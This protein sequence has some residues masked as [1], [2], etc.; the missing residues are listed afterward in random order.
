MSAICRGPEA[1]ADQNLSNLDLQLNLNCA[2]CYIN[3]GQPE[4][5]IQFCDKALRRREQMTKEQVTKAL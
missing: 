1:L 2:Q 3:L 4:M 5:G